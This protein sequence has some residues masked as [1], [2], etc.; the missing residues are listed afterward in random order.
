MGHTRVLEPWSVQL[1]IKITLMYVVHAY[2]CLPV[3]YILEDC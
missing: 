3:V 1:K 2:V